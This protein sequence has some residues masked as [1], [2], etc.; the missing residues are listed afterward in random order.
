MFGEA[1]TAV[2]NNGRAKTASWQ[3]ERIV[4]ESACGTKAKVDSQRRRTETATSVLAGRH[5]WNQGRKL[6][7]RKEVKSAMG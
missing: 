4:V 6:C 7:T 2:L 3:K 1:A 5:D